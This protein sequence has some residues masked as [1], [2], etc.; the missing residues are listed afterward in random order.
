MFSKH[1]LLLFSVWAGETQNLWD[2]GFQPNS[3]IRVHA[4]RRTSRALLCIFLP[5]LFTCSLIVWCWNADVNSDISVDAPYVCI[6]ITSRVH[7]VKLDVLPLTPRTTGVTLCCMNN[8]KGG[9]YQIQLK[10][11]T[12]ICWH[13]L[14]FRQQRYCYTAGQDGQRTTY[15]KYSDFCSFL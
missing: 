13:F 5:A 14:A 15:R 3:Y 4:V 2:A 6:K 8:H 9:F 11:K 10:S 7:P 12:S 1:L